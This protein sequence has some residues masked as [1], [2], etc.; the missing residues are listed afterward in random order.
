MLV[1]RPD[2]DDPGEIHRHD[3]RDVGDAE[4]ARRDELAAFEMNVQLVEEVLEPLHTALGQ[5]RDL[6][7]VHRPRQGAVH[8]RRAAVAQCLGHGHQPLELHPP[9][10][11]GDLGLV[12]RRAA[13]QRRFGLQGLHI[14]RDGRVVGQHRALVGHQRRHRAVRVDAAERRAEMLAAAQVDLHG[15]VRQALFGQQD[16]RAARAGGGGAVV[17]GDHGWAA[18]LSW[19]RVS[20][21]RASCRSCSWLAGSPKVRLTIRP[22]CTAG[23][24]AISSA[25]RLTWVYSCTDRNSPA[26]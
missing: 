14:G 17:Q 13:Q 16:A 22:R 11:A 15:L 4:L 1:A 6:R 8:H 21:S 5:G 23:R 7:I 20:K 25:Q 10:P 19:V 2:L 24:C 18:S 3:G 9:L 26:P 12:Q